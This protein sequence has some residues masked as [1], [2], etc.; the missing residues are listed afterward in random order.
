QAQFDRIHR[1][2][3]TLSGAKAAA[4]TGDTIVV[5][6]G[7][8][9]EKNLLKDGVDWHFTVGAIVEYTGRADGG[10]FDDSTTGENDVV[11]CVISGWG[12]FRRLGSGSSGDVFKIW[13]PGSKVTAT[14]HRATGIARGL[15]VA[16]DSTTELIARFDSIE[17]SDGALDCVGGYMYAHGRSAICDNIGHENDGGVAEIH[18]D[19]LEGAD[20]GL[21]IATPPGPVSRYTIHRIVGGE[22]GIQHASGDA[23]VVADRIESTDDAT[24][25][26]GGHS[27]RVRGAKIVNLGTSSAVH[28]WIPDFVLQDCILEPGAGAVEAGG[29]PPRFVGGR[30]PKAFVSSQSTLAGFLAVEQATTNLRRGDF[31][32]LTTGAVHLLNADDPS[33]ASSYVTL[34]P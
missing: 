15:A 14:F 6:P 29:V 23:V 17:T 32:K 4:S 13:K 12:E 27:L 30:N 28:S 9:D 7:T 5:H 11:R 19:L 18:L 26:A 8:Y 3:K 16:G 22:T 31:V 33:A 2:W 21:W 20:Q 24:V 25:L 10:L 34:V 1:P